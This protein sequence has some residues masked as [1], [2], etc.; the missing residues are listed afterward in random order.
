MIKTDI[1]KTYIFEPNYYK[2]DQP[3]IHWEFLKIYNNN[4]LNYILSIKIFKSEYYKTKQIKQNYVIFSYLKSN[5]NTFSKVKNYDNTK[6][7]IIYDNGYDHAIFNYDLNIADNCITKKIDKDIYIT[8]FHKKYI[9][10]KAIRI[11]YFYNSKHCYAKK[12]ITYYI[13]YYIIINFN[14]KYIDLTNKLR[15]CNT[16]FCNFSRNFMLFI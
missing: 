8:Y 2:Y 16:I 15:N 6:I 9:N 10:N 13:N 3:N 4:N 11:H 14:I 7:D 12:Y 5:K 1:I